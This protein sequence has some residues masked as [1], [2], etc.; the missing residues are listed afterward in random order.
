MRF[1]AVEE[2]VDKYEKFIVI[3][4]LLIGALVRIQYL[5]QES[6]WNDETVYMWLS[7]EV[8]ENPLFLFSRWPAYH[9]YSHLF[10][11]LSA[12]LGIFTNS[13]YAT[14]IVS[15]FFA[16]LSVLA[17]Y[18]LGRETM[19][20][21]EGASAALIMALNG[22]HIF[23][24]DKSLLEAPITA[25][26]AVLLIAIMRFNPEDVKSAVWLGLATVLCFLTKTS[27][28][29]AIPM[30]GL[31]LL[32]KYPEPKKWLKNP[33][34]WVLGAA[35]AVSAGMYF[36][37]NYLHFGNFML[38][39]T[40][41][42]SQT[43]VFGGSRTFYLENA[44]ALYSWP[45]F[46]LG[47]LGLYF[48]FTKGKELRS[49]S[50]MFLFHT[51]FFSFLVGEKVPR[52]GLPTVPLIALLA[53]Y[54]V[55]VVLDK[56]KLP[57][58]ITGFT[59]LLGIS[60]LVYGMTLLPQKA[61][62]YTGFQ[63]LGTVA[64]KLDAQNNYSVIYAQSTRQ[65]RAF[66]GIN[67]ESMEGKIRRLPDNLTEFANQTNILLQIDIWEYAGPEWVY[68]L[69]QEK[70]NRIINNNFTLLHSVYRDYPTQEGLRSVPVGLLLAK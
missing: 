14:R 5:F 40:A 3:G 41:A 15:L 67:Y 6:V 60:S 4:L 27:G 36:G 61:F 13:F 50:V 35:L 11:S 2:F 43:V 38:G 68:P 33:A 39:D 51:F 65:I 37:N 56:L 18:Y 24:S 59:F 54:A 30:A 64:G 49:A 69:T 16:L 20:K 12:V 1:E 32:V 62:T 8:K 45:L 28:F 26:Y 66:S 47:L 29:L 58:F 34:F 63:E 42:L 70:L 48:S 21:I 46:A 55:K 25:M 10:V 52:Y 57:N 23:F 31:A 53:V 17:V 7:D 22:L 9:S 44:G 19:G